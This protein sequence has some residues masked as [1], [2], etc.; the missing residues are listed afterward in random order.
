MGGQLLGALFILISDA[1]KA[2]EDA[3]PPFHMGRALVFQA[4]VGVAAVLPVMLLGLV[5]K[6]G[7]SRLSVDKA[8]VR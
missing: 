5:G 1:L 6:G 3:S 2:G 4:V 7:V 8:A